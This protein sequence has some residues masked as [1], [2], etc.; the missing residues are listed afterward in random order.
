M[1]SMSRW[2][3]SPCLTCLMLL[4]TS[5][6]KISLCLEPS[7]LLFSKRPQPTGKKEITLQRTELVNEVGKVIRIPCCY[8]VIAICFI[9]NII[10]TFAI[11]FALSSYVIM[12]FEVQIEEFKIHI[13]AEVNFLFKKELDQ[14]QRDSGFSP[15][16]ARKPS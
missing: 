15:H 16:S 1:L 3:A 5:S 13:K 9:L 7:L 12:M 10:A 8:F 11:F 2:R 4:P 14:G 6:F